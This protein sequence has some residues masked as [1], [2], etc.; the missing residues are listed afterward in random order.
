M[1]SVGAYESDSGNGLARIETR[2]DSVRIL[3][4]SY[5]FTA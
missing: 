4:D 1:Q 5:A 3:I 2:C